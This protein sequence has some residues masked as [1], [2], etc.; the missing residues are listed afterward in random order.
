MSIVILY[1]LLFTVFI[2]AESP[3][4]VLSGAPRKH[5]FSPR[6]HSGTHF[7]IR[8]TL[9]Y[10]FIEYKYISVHDIRGRREA[11]LPGGTNSQTGYTVRVFHHRLST[12]NLKQSQ[13][14]P[15]HKTGGL[16]I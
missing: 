7:P 8:G 15:I 1:T 14:A 6:T 4:G 10:V 2:T 12:E 16:F 13:N 5:F 11:L 9:V 3:G